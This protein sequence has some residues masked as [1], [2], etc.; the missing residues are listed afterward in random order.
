MLR[1]RG[2]S[3]Q[4]R[5]SPGCFWFV[6][7]TPSEAR[8]GTPFCPCADGRPHWA[9]ERTHLASIATSRCWRG[10]ESLARTRRSVSGGARR[11]SVLQK[12]G[13]QENTSA[14]VGGVRS[15]ALIGYRKGGGKSSAD[16]LQ[17]RLRAARSPPRKSRRP[18]IRD[19]SFSEARGADQ[20]SHFSGKK[21]SSSIRKSSLFLK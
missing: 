14:A 18:S 7:V 17:V 9:R 4:A 5:L 1:G 2:S 15:R 19:A 16:G 12:I 21:S 20:Y 3:R 13:A 11:P 10:G 8:G 6:L